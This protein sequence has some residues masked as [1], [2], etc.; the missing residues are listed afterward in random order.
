MENLLLSRLERP[1][2]ITMWDF[3]WLERRWPG[4]GYENIGQ[5]LDALAERGYDAVRIDAYPHLVSAD[6]TAEWELLPCWNQQDWGSP[7]LNRVRVQP[8]LDAFIAACAARGIK[9][10]LSTWYR[11]DR[12]GL[13]RR[14]L[15]P[16]QQADQ[17][18]AT[19]A[20]IAPELRAH[21]LYVDLCNEWPLDVWAPFF[22]GEHP[23]DWTTPRSLDWMGRALARFRAAWPELPVTFSTCHEPERYLDVKL[24]GFDFI[25]HHLWMASATDFYRRI[26]YN[27]ERFSSVGYENLV[28]HAEPLYRA[29]PEHWQQLL[30][31]GIHTLA[32]AARRQG[33]PLVT[34]ECWAIVD[35]KDWPLLDWGW[36]KE[37]NVLGTE[38]AVETG[39]WAAIST[40]NFCGPQF[41]GMWDDIAWHQRLTRLI[42]SAPLPSMKP[43]LG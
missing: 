26:G 35:Y 29:S 36:V 3:S 33:L 23:S 4:A 15:T 40:S 18:I 14:I 5:A 16:E 1:R 19:V 25:E 12:Q 2:A 39:A 9:V 37:L 30:R 42:R 21:L 38:W 8:H 6:P 43:G 22:V 31:E 24:P 41:R 34:T 20:A 10:A 32:D 27:Y 13:R 28:A 11:E 17:W 7:A